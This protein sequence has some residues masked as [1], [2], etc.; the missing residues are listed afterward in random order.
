MEQKKT[1][2]IDEKDAFQTR[3]FVIKWKF[4]TPDGGL[5]QPG[6]SFSLK[7]RGLG[8]AD[9][10]GIIIICREGLERGEVT[11]RL[12]AL[13]GPDTKGLGGPDTK[14]LGGPDTKS[15]RFAEL[16]LTSVSQVRAE[17]GV[18]TIRGRNATIEIM[19]PAV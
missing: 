2:I 15:H 3:A 6:Q 14:G 8:R 7:A 16:G 1:I 11:G 4:R 5:W 17:R 12:K 13:G 19:L 10:V 9:E 18:V